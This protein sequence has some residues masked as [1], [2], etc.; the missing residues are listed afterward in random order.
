MIRYICFCS[1][2]CIAK[3]E[4]LYVCVA[5]PQQRGAL[6]RKQKKTYVAVNV[7]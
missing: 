1:F 5:Y 2:V 4:I 7:L 6:T 3:D